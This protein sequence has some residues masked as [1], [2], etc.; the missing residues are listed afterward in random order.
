MSKRV[1]V[2]I[3]LGLGLLAATSLTAQAQDAQAQAEVLHG[4]DLEIARGATTCPT[5]PSGSGEST[6][7]RCTMVDPDPT[8]EVLNVMRD[9]G[10]KGMTMA[11]VTREIGFA[12]TVGRRVVVSDHGRV[13]VNG[14]PAEPFSAP[15]RPRLTR[16]LEA[17]LDRGAAMPLKPA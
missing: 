4:I 7:L 12:A 2:R 8:G 6:L 16:L 14:T 10:E 11:A 5:G 15:R 1:F 9:L 13:L 3:G 17:S